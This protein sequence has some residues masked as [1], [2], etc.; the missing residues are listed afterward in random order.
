[1]KIQGQFLWPSYPK[2][3][4][5]V[6]QP[7]PDDNESWRSIDEVPPEE[8]GL[9]MKNIVRDSLSI[10]RDRL[11]QYVARVFGFE[12]AGYQIQKALEATFEELVEARQLVLLD[13]RVSLPL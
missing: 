8:I 10:E 13:G 12:R 2:F 7:Q 1:L 11:L 5:V 9:A 4:L 3:E 6:R